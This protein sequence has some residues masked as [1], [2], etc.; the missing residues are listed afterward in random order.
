MST[1]YIVRTE[2]STTYTNK[3]IFKGCYVWVEEDQ[4]LYRILDDKEIEKADIQPD[5]LIT[6]GDVKFKVC[7][8]ANFQTAEKAFDVMEHN[9]N[10][11]KDFLRK[12][13]DEGK[14]ICIADQQGM[15]EYPFYVSAHIMSA[16]HVI[17]AQETITSIKNKC[18]ELTKHM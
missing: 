9:N 8:V 13:A 14:S 3:V 12:I 6:A 2:E 7:R 4:V 17:N 18:S 1:Q 10:Q 16:H 11:L 5:A 15:G